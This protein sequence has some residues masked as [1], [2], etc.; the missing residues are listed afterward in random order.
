MKKVLKVL[1]MMVMLFS[2]TITVFAQGNNS[3]V[4]EETIKQ[5]QKSDEN[6]AKGNKKVSN[7]IDEVNQSVVAVIGRNTKYRQDNSSQYSKI[8]M[9]LQHGSGVV[10]GSEGRIITNNHV[11][12]GLDD[13]FVVTYE[14]N[15]YKA[16]L[17][18]A[19]K[20]IDLALLSINRTDLK[21]MKF[22]QQEEIKVGDEVVAIGTPLFFGYRNSAS[23]GIISGLNRPVDDIYTYLQTDASINPGNSGGPLVNQ[24][25]QLVG[26]NTLGYTFFDGM[27]FSIPIGNVK[28]FI[29]QYD[30][31]GRIKRCFTGIEFEENWAALLGLPTNQGLKVI[32]IKKDGVVTKDQVK[33]GDTL[34]SIDNSPVTSI[35]QYNEILKAHL[36][37]DKV[38]LTFGR[39]EKKINITVELKEQLKGEK[40]K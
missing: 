39:D 33:E 3:V 37:G 26:I 35:A 21:P 18:Y 2:I 34:D 32:T 15:V 7:V 38:I 5:I 9:N 4:N 30:K 23:K 20:Q 10:V 14:G 28:Y 16:Q 31:F 6:Y 13:I 27:S 19:D 1:M 40:N 11:V 8:P 12:D 25:S 17:L 24:N 22:A 36:P 29:D